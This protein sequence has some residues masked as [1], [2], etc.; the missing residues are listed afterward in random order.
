[1]NFRKLISL[2]S[3]SSVSLFY[4]VTAMAAESI[5]VG[6]TAG[7]MTQV[8]DVAKKLAKEKYNLEIKTIT[9]VDYQIPNEALSNGDIDANIFQT[10]SFFEQSKAKMGYK[11]A[12][13]GNTF[14]YPMG[15]YSRKIKNLSE[16]NEKSI[17]VIPSDA[18]NQGRALNL[19]KTAGLIQ[20]KDGV[21]ELP[22]PRDI[23]ANPKKIIIK[24]ADGAQAA[25]AVQDV[26]AAVLN[27]DFVKNAGFTT[28]EALL[29]ENPSTA[30]PYINVIV[31]READKD[32]KVF[33]TLKAVMN[34][35]EVL[36]KT[37]EIFPGAV[38]AW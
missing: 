23:S 17:V 3:L 4:T 11:I 6:I 5:K 33:E 21:G 38:Q 31:T 37:Q 19:L 14:I 12:I 20:I 10:V 1:M 7:P 30:K 2:F 18:S 9:F 26:A 16:L 13:I 8:L 25:R 28:S 32:K 35:N 34:S 29:K 24:T 15:I 22:T 27:N 36:K